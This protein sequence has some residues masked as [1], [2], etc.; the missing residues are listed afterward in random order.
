MA[1]IFKESFYYGAMYVQMVVFIAAMMMNTP[2]VPSKKKE[3]RLF[4]NGDWLLWE[5]LWLDFYL[6]WQPVVL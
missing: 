2:A 4:I 6:T 1:E 3:K 5:P